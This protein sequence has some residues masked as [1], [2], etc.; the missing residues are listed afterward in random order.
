VR[1]ANRTACGKKCERRRETLG[2]GTAALAEYDDLRERYYTEAILDTA[3]MLRQLPYSVQAVFY[4]ARRE[5]NVS[6]ASWRMPGGGTQ[7]LMAVWPDSAAEEAVARR[8]HASLRRAFNLSAGEL[9]LLRLDIA[10]ASAAAPFSVDGGED[11]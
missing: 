11:E 2:A 7:H 6:E 9:P 8:V 4:I 1:A 10:P 5:R 3:Q